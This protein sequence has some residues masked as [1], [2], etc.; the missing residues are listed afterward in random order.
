MGSGVVL[1]T[2][3][4]G[5]IG[6]RIVARLALSYDVVILDRTP[7]KDPPAHVRFEMIDLTSEGS[8]DFAVRHVAERL[9]DKVASVIHLAAYF[10][11]TGQPNPKYQEITVLGTMRL[12]QAIRAL[13]VEQFV[14]SSTM[15]VHRPGKP[16]KPGEKIDEA[17]PMA[18]SFPGKIDEATP[19][20]PSFPYRASK[21]E[22][23]QLLEQRRGDLPVVILR[24]AGVYDDDCHNPFL[25]H[26]IARI[27]E[28]SVQGRIYPGDLAAG[29][30]FVHVD[31]LADAVLRTV[32]RRKE[33]GSKAAFLIGEP[34][35]IPFGQ[36]QEIIGEQTHGEAW[37]T[38]HVP[39]TLAKA[40]AWVESQVLGD[41]PFIRPYMVDMSDDHYD[42]DI[43]HARTVL[44]WQPEHRLRDQ[45]PVMIARLK[46]DPVAWY[47]ANHLDSAVVAG[48]AALATGKEPDMAMSMSKMM[49]QMEAMRQRMLWVYLATIGLGAWLLASPFQ[50]GLFDLQGFS[51][52]RDVTAERALWELGTRAGLNGWSDLASGLLL[53]AFGTMSLSKRFSWVPWGSCGVGLWLLFAPL[54]VWS[55]SAAAYAND[56][57]V[58]T[59]AIAFSVLV[60]MMPGMSHEGMM[61]KSDIPP[62]WS[63]SPSSWVQRLPMI[64]LGFFGFL[65][66]RQLTAYQMGFSDH[67]F[68]PFFA[69]GVPGR[70]GSEHIVTSAV[71]RA[72]PIA[73]GGLGATSY[74]IETLMGAMGS[75]KRWR[76]MPWMV[77]FFF[78]L[79]VPLGGV[80]IFFIVIQPIMI[81][82]YCTLCLVAAFAMLLM[83]PLTLDEVVAMIQFMIRNHR[84]GRPFWRTFFKGGPDVGGSVEK[85]IGFDQPLPKQVGDAVRGVTLP[86]TLLI[87]CAAAAWLMF[88]R[89]VFGTTGFIADNDHLVGAMVITVAVCAMA[90]VARPLRFLNVAFG[91]WL[92]LMPWLATGG[93]TAASVNEIV[94]GLLVIGLSLP[95]GQRSD[96]HYGS[97]DRYVV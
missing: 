55:P 33:L 60:P 16:G 42:L 24:P 51:P 80:S 74:L 18:P 37:T 7:P 12:L 27:F 15:L 57:V 8:L 96:A 17:T 43:A 5:F 32:E 70:N 58:G 34:D 86:W 10:D 40:G 90:E 84:A 67:I 29:Q 71:S 11:E 41:D 82:T 25:A 79:V 75:A 14:F 36:M 81:G 93:S 94:V 49:A 19:M 59:L 53:M 44:G 95:R 28:K 68:E 78:I 69:S 39:K 83:I 2:G 91:G 61:D 85:G 22:T 38:W 6:Q 9:G 23:E 3:G 45:L 87:V 47:R 97:F 46:A 26:Q 62:G 56:M 73:D 76:T 72:W 20:A 50:F 1:V 35:A 66:A 13:Q 30:S 92:V 65:I 77:T 88:S 48:D 4:S 54:L 21:I 89:L 64:A 63:Y 52:V 31:D